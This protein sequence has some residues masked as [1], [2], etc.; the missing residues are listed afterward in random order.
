ML[1]SA[2]I[3]LRQPPRDGSVTS[4]SC[5]PFGPRAPGSSPPWPASITTVSMRGAPALGLCG[6]ASSGRASSD[7]GTTFSFSAAGSGAWAGASRPCTSAMSG[8]GGTIG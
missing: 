6:L 1:G 2:S 7:G 5:V 4:F 8:S 3:D